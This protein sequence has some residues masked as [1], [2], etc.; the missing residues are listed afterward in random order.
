ML[1]GEQ[2]LRVMFLG[3]QHAA[4]SVAFVEAAAGLAA[5]ASMSATS[6][7]FGLGT[8]VALYSVAAIAS[9]RAR[10]WGLFAFAGLALLYSSL[11]F[12]VAWSVSR[13][14]WTLF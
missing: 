12:F 1:S 8:G 9:Y 3:D 10:A 2:T 6:W 11:V 4:R 14:H 7:W 5:V 13:S